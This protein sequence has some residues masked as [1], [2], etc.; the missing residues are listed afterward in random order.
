MYVLWLSFLFFR[1]RKCP[2]WIGF[3]KFLF[4]LCCDVPWQPNVPDM[5]YFA[6]IWTLESRFGTEVDV[7]DGCSEKKPKL[8]SQQ[9]RKKYSKF[10]CLSISCYIGRKCLAYQ[11]FSIISCF[12]FDRATDWSRQQ[13]T[14][15][16]GCSGWCTR[17]TRSR[18]WCEASINRRVHLDSETR[19]SRARPSISSMPAISQL[20]NTVSY[21]IGFSGELSWDRVRPFTY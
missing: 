9:R 18:C 8:N 19:A 10:N 20:P 14:G 3:S 7:L 2:Y 1:S 13:G 21:A 5:P 6:G 16:R 11:T 12:L 17:R 15:T 4:G